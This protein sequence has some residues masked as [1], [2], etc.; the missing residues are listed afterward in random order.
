[1]NKGNKNHGTLMF[2]SIL[3]PILLVFFVIGFHSNELVSKSMHFFLFLSLFLVI[4]LF[5]VTII[6][7]FR[8][9]KTMEDKKL[10][11]LP[12]ILSSIFLSL[13]ILG[14]STFLW[15]MYGPNPFFRDWLISSA[16][17]TMNHQYLA[18]WF[19]SEKEIYEALEKNKIVE[20]EEETDLNSIKLNG[21]FNK[22]YYE[23]EF[24]KEIFTLEDTSA[25]YK[26]IP[27]SHKN[28]E[29]FLAVIYDASRISVSTT[30]YL[31]AV[32][33]YVTEMASQ[34]QALLAI[35]GGSF[36]D[37]NKKGTGGIPYGVLIKNGKILSDSWQSDSGGV[38][39]FTKENKL[40]LGKMNAKEAIEKG[41]RD[42]VSFKPFLI[43]NGKKSFTS[44][45]GG[46]GTAPRTAIGQRKD[47]I[48][49]MLVVDGR[50]LTNPGATIVDIMNILY[51]YGAYNASN[52]DGGTSS[53]MVLPKDKAAKYIE[54]EDMATRCKK[55]YC[56]IN[57]IVN[58]SGEHTTRPVVSSF[59]LK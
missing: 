42:A 31:N 8:R 46:W 26:I 14:S 52:L 56:Y 47:G 19:Y 6:L 48:V 39:G 13:E 54:K 38:I 44:G 32:G 21:N 16:M 29:G 49:L 53:V 30:K 5:I 17:V 3:I 15:L 24:E 9:K 34:E 57:D 40:V 10:N 33:Q 41:I 22:D 35:N 11:K 25:P 59:V 23:N 1:M 28:F 12:K 51:D 2:T 27:I 50:T 55:D 45:N 20:T 36:L 58:G 18:T 4:S 37:E 43:V 7:L